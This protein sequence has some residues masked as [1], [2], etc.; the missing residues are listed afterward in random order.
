MLLDLAYLLAAV[1]VGPFYMLSRLVKR[2]RTASPKRRLGF[3]EAP[4]GEG[5]LVWIHGVSVGEVLAA[6]SIVAELRRARPQARIVITSTTV[7]GLAVA[8][9]TYPDLTVLE[10]PFDLSGAVRR[11][12][13]RVRPSVLVLMEL[14]LW[15]NL[16]AG[17]RRAGVPVLVA[18]AKMSERSGRGYRRMLRVMPRFMDGISAFLTQDATYADRIRALG[19]PAARVE[20]VGNLKYDNVTYDDTRPGRGSLRSEHGYAADAPIV[21]FGSTHPGEDEIV[22]RACAIV[23][24][25]TPDLRVVLAP[26]HPER[27]AAVAA[28]AVEAGWR[29]GRRSTPDAEPDPG[30]LVVDTMGELASLYGLADVAFVGGTLVPVGGHNPLE[31]A[32]LG[33]PLV[34]GPHFHT[35]AETVDELRAAKALE[36]VSDAETLAASVTRWLTDEGARA[37]AA[38][39]AEAVISRHKGSARR[40]IRTLVGLLA[41]TPDTDE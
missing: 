12:L 19:V 41:R 36:I 17:C 22:L 7:T 2:K 24:A 14:E 28:L 9:E 4:A 1:I 16:I 10:S 27:I 26:R 31:P 35:V 20:V 29:V 6:R 33:L 25:T 34:V 40:T 21:I 38:Q 30:V 32:A 23:R 8:R 39:G 11:F 13:R 3:V 18:N 15:P 37:R 5:E